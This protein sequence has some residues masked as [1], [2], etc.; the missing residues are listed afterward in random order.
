MS[1]LLDGDTRVLVQGTTGQQA[2]VHV[3]YMRRILRRAGGRT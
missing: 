3:Q 2:R 1:I